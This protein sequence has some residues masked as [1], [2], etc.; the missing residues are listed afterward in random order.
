[1]HLKCFSSQS[2]LDYSQS[3]QNNSLGFELLKDLSEQESSRIFD[4]PD[5]D[6]NL[7][8]GGVDFNWHEFS[9]NRLPQF[10]E[11]INIINDAH[12]W[13]PTQ[14]S[15]VLISNDI[16]LPVVNVLLVNKKQMLA[17]FMTLS[18]L[19]PIATSEMSFHKVCQRLTIQGSAGTGKSQVI[20]ILS[21]LVM[22][23]FRNKQ[24]VLN[25]AP[26][27]AASVLLPNGRTIHSTTNI[28]RVSKDDKT[29]SRSDKP[30]NLAQMKKMKK[31]LANENGDMQVMLINT[32]EKGMIGQRVM[33]WYNDRLVS[34][35][36]ALYPIEQFGFPISDFFW[37][38]TH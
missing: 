7:F 3:S 6:H 13:L 38:Y 17:I 31:L 11:D 8:D 14:M 9:H 23:I 36:S 21:R 5:L 26:T 29:V 25:C 30:M 27:G 24:A 4:G 32:D 33:G 35:C 37:M 10:T 2:S 20:K 34:A 15:H 28:P 16:H 19:M 12:R 1:M 22:R 18:K